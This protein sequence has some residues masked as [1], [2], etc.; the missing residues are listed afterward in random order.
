MKKKTVIIIILLLIFIHCKTKKQTVQPKTA[1]NLPAAVSARSPLAIAKKRWPN[2]TAG[3]LKEGK[4][5][6]DTQC[7]KCHSQK[8]IVT[9]DENYWI[10]QI[11][12]MSP[13]AHLT[14]EEKEKLI[15]YVL[16]FREANTSVD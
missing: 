10:K 4:S 8:N 2:I 11:N 12:K 6:F 15:H 5:I 16:S 1:E 7:T 13:R 14:P 9:R 3:D